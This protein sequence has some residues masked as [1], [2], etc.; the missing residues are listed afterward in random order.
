MIKLLYYMLMNNNVLF[1]KIFILI[2]IKWKDQFIIFVIFGRNSKKK[3][4]WIN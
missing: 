3:N 4:K 1:L 2:V